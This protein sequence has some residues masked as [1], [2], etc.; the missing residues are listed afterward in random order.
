MSA[1]RVV[2]SEPQDAWAEDFRRI[3]DE[4][5]ALFDGVGQEIPDGRDGPLQIEHIGSTSVPGLCAKPVIDV[6]L[7]AAS[8]AVIEARIGALQRCG[9]DY[10]GAY[11]ALLPER[12]YFVRPPAV[13]PR[14]HLHGV[15]RG[16][17]L[18][19][20]HLVFRDALRADATLA[21][22]YGALKRQLAQAHADD[23]EA[24][25]DAKGPFIRQVLGEPANLE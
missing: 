10:R 3:A 2:L 17:D 16:G 12:R 15:V 11:E 21:A 6:L 5:R 19:R 8:L 1:K 14:V 25:T 13:G 18:W 4:V 24:Y 23:A 22:R 9:Y 20:R 7:G